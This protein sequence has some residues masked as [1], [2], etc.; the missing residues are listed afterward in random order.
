L[1][2]Q[3]E[4][5]NNDTGVRLHKWWYTAAETN[6]SSDTSCQVSP[7]ALASL[8]NGSYRWR[9]QDY[10]A[11][12]YGPWTPYAY[13]TLNAACYT[14]TTA[15]NP[16]GSGT[17]NASPVQN[18]TG[19]YLAGTVVQLTAAPATGY[20]FANWS[21]DASGTTNPVSV[22]MNANLNVTANLRGVT[23]IAPA[24]T[25]TAWDNTFSWNGLSGALNYQLE[26]YDDTSGVRLL[27]QW[28]SAAETNCS[29]DTSC[30]VSPS[31]LAS[32]A[33]GS[34][35]WRVQE[36]GPYG[37]GAWSPYTYFTLNAACYTLT[38]AVNPPGSGTVNVGT[39][40]NC[41]GGYLAGTVVQLTAAP[42]TGFAFAS[43]SGDASGTTNPVSVTMNANLNVTANLRGVFL[44]A[45]EGTLTTWDETFYWTG[46]AEAAQYQLEVYDQ[47]SGVRLF[48][49]WFTAA[50]AAC[51][52]DTSCQ[53]TPSALAGLANGNYRWRIQ[54]YGAYGYGPWSQ[55][56]YFTLNR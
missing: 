26:V 38:T 12:G 37:Y 51:N 5:Y 42:A 28:F 24:N 34:Y 54:D 25:L 11:Y 14:L 47:T 43:W 1:A 45:P 29:S 39:A 6:C 56:L 23:L 7:S 8:T 19:G 2:Y 22:T 17:V 18:C 10:G 44:L 21:G 9:I 50:A 27:K 4:V 16:T 52:T 15:V 41:T 33:N 53:V 48:K 30:Q 36:F 35:R 3:L 20:A 31:A 32:L 49:Q 55:Y 40:Q 46:F 13:F